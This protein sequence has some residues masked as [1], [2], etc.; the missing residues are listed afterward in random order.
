MMAARF[1][2]K[3]VSQYIELTLRDIKGDLSIEG[4]NTLIKFTDLIHGDFNPH[5]NLLVAKDGTVK[6]ID[7]EHSARGPI[8][9]DF[10]YMLVHLKLDPKIMVDYLNRKSL[11]ILG[12]NKK[13]GTHVRMCF[14]LLIIIKLN[15]W[16]NKDGLN[17]K[18]LSKRLAMLEY[19]YLIVKH[20]F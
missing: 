9:F 17:K 12:T 1:N 15:L 14:L 19:N 6:V 10:F 4:E 18:S 2:N 11:I 7:W 16:E 3:K 20:N 8:L 13:I 5:N